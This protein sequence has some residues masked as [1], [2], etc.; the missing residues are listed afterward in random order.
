MLFEIT[1]PEKSREHMKNAKAFNFSLAE[2]DTSN[3]INN[4]K[5]KLKIISTD[6]L[7]SKL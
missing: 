3:D 7:T 6:L 5:K 2:T 1:L 4:A